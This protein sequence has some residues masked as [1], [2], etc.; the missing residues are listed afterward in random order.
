MYIDNNVFLPPSK[1]HMIWQANFITE[2]LITDNCLFLNVTYEMR[3]KCDK[4]FKS[5][6]TLSTAEG[7]SP[8]TCTDDYVLL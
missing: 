3:L 1:S 2:G 7:P 6:G 5:A 8:S 4:S